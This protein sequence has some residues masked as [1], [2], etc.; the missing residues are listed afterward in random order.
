MKNCIVY[1]LNSKKED[2]EN[3]NKSISLVRKNLLPNTKNC[4]VIIFHEKNLDKSLINDSSKLVF[5]EIE[6]SIEQYPKEISNK[7]LEYFPHPTHQNG[8]IAYWHKGFTM[9]YRHMC[10]FFSFEVFKKI[11][12][13]RTYMRLDSDSYILESVN[14][15]IFEWFNSNNLNYAC[16]S[17][18]I[19]IDNQKVCDGFNNFVKEV[20]EKYNLQTFLNINEIPNG[21]LFYTNFEMCNVGWFL[22]NKNIEILSKE[23]IDSGNIFLKRWGDHIIRFMQIS[24]FSESEKVKGV[25]GLKYQH[26]AIYTT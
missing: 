22:N 6:F 13:Y 18:A 15:D 25:S 19:Q 26:G 11:Q 8:P 24:L 21:K 17:E 2:V 10:S 20:I 1:L 16:V 23:I 4:D 7:F 14:Y 3:F 9:G 12:G 5:L